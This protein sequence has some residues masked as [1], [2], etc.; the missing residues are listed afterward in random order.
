M[1]LISIIKE[2]L[3]PLDETDIAAMLKDVPHELFD[4]GQD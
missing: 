3:M 4:E 2:K 1:E